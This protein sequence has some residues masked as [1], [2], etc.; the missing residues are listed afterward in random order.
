MSDYLQAKFWQKVKKTPSCWLWTGSK[1]LYGLF[2]VTPHHR[3]GAHRYAYK[4]AFGEVPNGM[5][6]CHKCDVPI[7]VN[8]D[9]LFL[10]TPRDNADDMIQKG[11]A[12]PPYGDR[13]GR[14]KLSYAIVQDIRKAYISGVRIK[15]LATHYGVRR[16]AIYLAVK[17]KT[18]ARQS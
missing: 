1:A 12:N 3:V 5:L 15:D 14:K 7:C 16:E 13:S 8:P 17:Y 2:R 9:H 10:G 6:V 11:R 4:L 18:W